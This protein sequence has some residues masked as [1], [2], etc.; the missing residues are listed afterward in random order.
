LNYLSNAIKFTAAGEVAVRV[1]SAP[2]ADG[3]QQLH[4]AVRDT[5]MGI[6]AERFDRLFHSFSQVDA[7]TH[8]QF[9]GTGLGLAICKRLAELMRGR[10]WAESTVGE[11]STFHFAVLAGLPKQK[12]MPALPTGSPATAERLVDV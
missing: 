3:M 10:V 8:R 12:Q 4:F 9:G 11:G 2:G 6:P 1:A 5:G 7:S